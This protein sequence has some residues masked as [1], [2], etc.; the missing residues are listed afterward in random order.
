MVIDIRGN[1]CRPTADNPE[2]RPTALNDLLTLCIVRWYAPYL[3]GMYNIGFDFSSTGHPPSYLATEST[4]HS[5]LDLRSYASASWMSHLLPQFARPTPGSSNPSGALIRNPLITDSLWSE[6]C[7]CF[8]TGHP[9]TSYILQYASSTDPYPQVVSTS[10]SL[11][12]WKPPL[13]SLYTP[14]T[15]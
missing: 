9:L 4:T 11:T 8:A 5:W 2:K 1:E 3:Y 12:V 6:P 7:L 13:I 14:N 15:G 10:M